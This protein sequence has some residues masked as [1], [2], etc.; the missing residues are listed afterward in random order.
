MSGEY[1]LTD[2]A[3][4]DIKEGKK[5]DLKEQ[6]KADK[7]KKQNAQYDK[8]AESDEEP[9]EKVKSSKPDVESLRKYLYIYPVVSVL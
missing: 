8:P 2:K 1:F 7:V 5:R 4:E 9:Q 3:K 6:R